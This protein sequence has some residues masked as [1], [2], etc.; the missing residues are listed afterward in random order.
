MLISIIWIRD[1][2]YFNLNFKGC[3]KLGILVDGISDYLFNLM[4]MLENVMYYLQ[5]NG[6]WNF[7]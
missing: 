1:F 2:I 3:N 5:D 7:I 4:E 6:I